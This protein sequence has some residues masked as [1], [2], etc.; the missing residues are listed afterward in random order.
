MRTQHTR[1]LVA[2]LALFVA[3][4]SDGAPRKGSPPRSTPPK[5]QSDEV[6]VP[7]LIGKTR[8]EAMAI[9][10]AAGFAQDLESSRPLECE[11]APKVEGRINC[12]DPEPGKRVKRYTLVQ[13]NVYKPTRLQ[14]M[15]VRDQLLALIGLPPDEARAK[16]KSYG[17]DGT[18]TVT[19]DTKFHEKC[20][21][22][23]VCAFDV[24]EAGIGVHDPITLFTNKVTTVGTPPPD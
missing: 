10:R 11:N 3:S 2:A 12:Q 22:G 1:I 21:A 9:V 16:L 23:R 14:G 17:H 5:A 13:I 18:V 7:D 19:P 20:A 15:V 4:S 8:D 24:A 6:V